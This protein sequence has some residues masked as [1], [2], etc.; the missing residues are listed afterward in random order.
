MGCPPYTETPTGAH[1][2]RSD[3]QGRGPLGCRARCQIAIPRR[4]LLGGPS[5]R[6]LLNL[7]VTQILRLNRNPRFASTLA[8]WRSRSGD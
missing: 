4:F 6:R 2:R 8:L 7:S 1:E 5:S 3:E